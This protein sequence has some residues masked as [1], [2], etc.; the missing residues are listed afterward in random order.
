MKRII[1]FLLL[2][3]L[4]LTA[5]ASKVVPPATETAESAAATVESA[6]ETIDAA[7]AE[8]GFAEG[9]LTGIPDYTLPD[10]ADTAL[11]RE[12]AVRAM[13]D[14]ISTRWTPSQDLKYNKDG[15]VSEKDFHFYKGRLYAGLPYTEAGGSLI[16]FLQYYDFET[17]VVTV[18][19]AH[20][21]NLI[22]NV[23][24]GAVMWGWAAVSHTLH[25]YF[26]SG[27]MTYAQGVIPVGSW[28][29]PENV[30]TF[31]DYHTKRIVEENGEDV[32]M[33][34]YA[35][36]KM[37]DGLTSSGDSSLGRHTMMAVA[38][39]KVVYNN[40][41]IDPDA[42]TVLIQ[43]QR[44]GGE[45]DGIPT[46]EGGVTVRYSGRTEASV[47]FRWLFD[48]HFVPLTVKELT[49][50]EPYQAPRIEFA[51][52]ASSIASLLQSTVRSN[53]ALCT[54]RMRVT[55]EGGKEVGGKFVNL[56]IRDTES[57]DAYDFPLNRFSLRKGDTLWCDTSL[58]AGKNYHLTLSAVSAAG[59][60]TALADLDFTK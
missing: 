15:A 38:D 21:N 3:T 5:C 45:D 20:V 7:T 33:A 30:E 56:T 29:Y 59:S 37:A 9:H 39:A 43:D 13:R 6:T 8:E 35:Q 12:T 57:G 28:T 44:G 31:H 14:M 17:G 16:Q 58:K 50:E 25:G 47:T 52:D 48:N 24:G 27:Y 49:G 1:A 51:G 41:R 53:L 18:D 26:Q 32:M 22:G 46:E 23:C 60:E 11:V 55:E 42:S 10:G 36:M 2:L 34:S 40:G 4:T 54:V 19:P